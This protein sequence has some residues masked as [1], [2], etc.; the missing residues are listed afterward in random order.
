MGGSAARWLPKGGG[1]NSRR[2]EPQVLSC[3]ERRC[4]AGQAPAGGGFLP[5]PDQNLTLTEPN[6]NSEAC[7]HALTKP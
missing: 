4:A 6:Q 7:C 5:G 3:G 2:G 1:N